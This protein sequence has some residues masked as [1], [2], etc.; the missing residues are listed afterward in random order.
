MNKFLYIATL[1]LWTNIF[2]S[3][4]SW[5]EFHEYTEQIKMEFQEY[6][7]KQETEFERF[8]N[9][10]NKEFAS[11]L[12]ETWKTYSSSPARRPKERPEP[13]VPV[14]YDGG[15][16]KES[17]ERLPLPKVIPPLPMI[18]DIPLTIVPKPDLVQEKNLYSIL[19]YN[20][21]CY[22]HDIPDKNIYLN[23]L[24]EQAVGECWELLSDN[25][26]TVWIDD[27]VRLKNDLNLCDWAYIK[28]I[29]TI[30]AHIFPESHDI[31]VIFS[32][33]L[34]VQTG[35]DVKVCRIGQNLSTLFHTNDKL[36]LRKYYIINGKN[37]YPTQIVKQSDDIKTYPFDFSSKS[38]PI[39]VIMNKYL[40]FAHGTTDK[41]PY[42]SAKW[43]GAS[44]FNISINPSVIQFYEEYP[45][46]EWNL[47]GQ[48]AVSPEFNE[49]ILPVFGDLIVGK[50]QIEA[51]N[52]LLDYVQHGFA[53]KTDNNQFGYEKPFFI[54]ENF[55]YPFND[56]EDRAILFARLVHDL[57][58]MEVI[59]LRYPGH[60]ATAVLFTEP[61]EGDAVVVDEKHY[62][63]CD[64]TYIGAPVGKSMPHYRTVQAE[65]VHL[66]LNK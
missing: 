27:C 63:V 60:L 64:P 1:I 50:S 38:I 46:C 49:L 12:K 25:K 28:L 45:L 4:Q 3:S 66:Q 57:L 21:V 11:Y 40:L 18:E 19:F 58:K 34:L 37:Y 6:K 5:K 30:S 13:I 29:E 52:I 61:V 65:V 31:Q 22:I 26:Y 62:I 41:Q 16:I 10:R 54:E 32:T 24:T 33:F 56:C 51:V 9:T 2:A 23:N 47:Y 43:K 7:K 8:R 53:Y 59:Y 15:Q 44:P 39:R 36:F 14:I 55:Y 20:T 17:P 48:A 35:Y 42:S